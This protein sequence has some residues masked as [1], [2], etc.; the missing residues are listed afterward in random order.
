M[1]CDAVRPRTDGLFDAIGAGYQ[2]VSVNSQDRM[3]K[4]TCVVQILCEPEDVGETVQV[5]LS[6]LSPSGQ[7]LAGCVWDV[8]ATA[9]AHRDASELIGRAVYPALRLETRVK[10]PGRHRLVVFGKERVLAE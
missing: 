5:N 2:F 6:L 1:V 4:R 10:E 9:P 7:P 8:S 3:F